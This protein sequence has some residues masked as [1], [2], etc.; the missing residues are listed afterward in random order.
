MAED[1]YGFRAH[2]PALDLFDDCR[3][4]ARV[5]KK[6]AVN[7]DKRANQLDA[8]TWTKNS[9][10]VWRD[11]TK[12]REER[13]YRHPATFPE[14][15]VR[16]L[17][18]S[19]L[20][21][22]GQRVLDPFLGIGTTLV[23]AAKLGHSGIGF[24][25]Y[26]QYAGIASARLA[27]YSDKCMVI[28][29]SALD[30]CAHIEPDSVNMVVTSPPYWNVLNR[31][32][33]IHFKDIR[34]YGTDANDIGNIGDYDVFLERL[35]VIMRGVFAS[36]APKA[37]CIVNVMDIRVKDRFY[38]LHSDLYG[39]MA[40][41]GFALDDII[42]WDRGSEYHALCPLGYP[43]RFRLNRVHEYLLIFQ[44]PVLLYKEAQSQDSGESE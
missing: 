8:K 16:R 31:K 28:N 9:I 24:E 5:A 23:A 20:K 29:G 12:T 27:P 11:I 34:G 18:E 1:I 15:M 3:L 17:L 30:L 39:R 2:Q 41:I 40:T 21:E 10:S 37:Y 33:S 19:F 44:K 7:P 36:L 4:R 14:S 22:K 35:S 6:A 13:S 25:I 32:R 26:P 42:I 43:Y 38:T